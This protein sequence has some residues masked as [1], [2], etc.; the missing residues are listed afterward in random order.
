MRVLILDNFDSF[1]YN[2]VDYFRQLGSGVRVVRNTASMD[3]VNAEDFDQLVLSPG[4]ATPSESGNLMEV[5]ASYH[6]CR[7]IFG[8]CLGH[9]ALAEFFGG[10]LKNIMPVH[11]KAVDIQHDGRGVFWGIEQDVAVARYHSWAVSAVPRDMEVSSFTRDGV[12]MGIR[13]RKWPIEGVQ[14]HPESVLTMRNAAGIRMIR[15]VVEGR[16]GNN[17]R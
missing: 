6:Q 16:I 4:P 5:I 2:L 8:V 14:F 3:E 11:G 9:Q 10:T 7:P 17:A 13:H 1:T 15:N 12:I